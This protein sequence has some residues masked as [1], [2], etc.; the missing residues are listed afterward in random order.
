MKRILVT[1]GSGFVGHA[2]LSKL[3]DRGFEVHALTRQSISDATGVTWH[4]HDLLHGDTPADLLAS[5]RPTHLLHLAWCTQ[6]GSFGSSPENLLWLERTIQL[7]RAFRETGGKR[8]V[9]TG[10]CFEYQWSEEECHERETATHPSTIYGLAKLSAANYLEALGR[11][12]LSTAWARLFFLYGP[13]A[14]EQRMPGVV[15]SSLRIGQPALCSDGQQWRDFLH[16]EDAS[17]ALVRLV[18]SDVTGTVN[19]CSGEP[20]MIR[21]MASTVAE[22]MGHPDLLRLGARPTSPGDPPRIAGDSS[23]LRDE[24]NWQPRYDLWEGLRQ[25]IEAGSSVGCPAVVGRRDAA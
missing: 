3:I 4:S 13:G 6:P 1:G 17:E 16:I 2:C 23:R 5:I 25:T 10:S 11:V 7:F 12:G 8:I 9:A 22:L 15:I 19:V 14:S 24:L 20:V 18:D 21:Q